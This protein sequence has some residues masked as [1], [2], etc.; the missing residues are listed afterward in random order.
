MKCLVGMTGNWLIVS[1]RG[2]LY[3]YWAGVAA[4]QDKS[5]REVRMHKMHLEREDINAILMLCF[6]N[7]ETVFIL[8]CTR[9]NEG[10]FVLA[11]I[12]WSSP[13]CNVDVVE[14]IDLRFLYAI[15]WGSPTAV[16]N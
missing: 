12:S 7:N 15:T 6:H 5:C 3:T 8:V 10:R 11:K 4:Y 9:D 14:S 1:I 16:R 2:I 13:I